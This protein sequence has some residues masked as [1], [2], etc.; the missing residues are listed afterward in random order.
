MKYLLLFLL[1][2]CI[3]SGVVTRKASGVYRVQEP[4]IMPYERQVCM[5]GATYARYY[6]VKVKG[7]Y[8]RWVYLTESAYYKIQ[9]GDSLTIK[10]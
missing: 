10:K 2:S 3:T 6:R 5:F 8:S 7:K 1:S 9:I 4:Y